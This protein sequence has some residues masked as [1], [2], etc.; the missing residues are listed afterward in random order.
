MLSSFRLLRTSFNLSSATFKKGVQKCH[1]HI[2]ATPNCMPGKRGLL[3]F[4]KE[5]P[6]QLGIISS[7]RFAS[8]DTTIPDPPIPPP[9]EISDIQVLKELGILSDEDALK[10]EPKVSLQSTESLPDAAAQEN[11]PDPSITMEVFPGTSDTDEVLQ[12]TAESFEVP[13]ESSSN[14]Y[15]VKS[16][17]PEI[18]EAL[19]DLPVV[20][21]MASDLQEVL[22]HPTLE[23]VGLGGWGPIGLVQQ[24]LD[25][26]HVTC[27]IPW[28]GSIVVGT[29]VVRI[30]M[31]PLV[32]ISQRNAA[33][34]H[35]I[36]P[37][38][39]VIQVKMSDA[40]E[41]G[42]RIEAAR[43]AQEMMLFM[44]EKG[45][46]PLKNMLVPLAQAPLF[47]SFFLGLRGMA[48]LPVESMKAGGFAWFVDL[49][50]PDQF[51]LLPIITS[52]TLALTIEL[53]TDTARLNSSNMGLMKYFLR[54]MPIIIFPF[55]VGFPSGI[56]VYWAST[57]FISLIQVSILKIPV[58][59]DF[60]K[61][62]KLINHDKTKLPIKDKGFVK[63][64]SDSWTNM[65]ITRELEERQRIDEINFMKAGRGAVKKTFKFDPTQKDASD[66]MSTTL[67]AKKR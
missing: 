19:P 2:Y 62:D 55:T 1:L 56:L 67:Q 47:I 59:R 32:I 57:N 25:F 35:N 65:K 12:S 20:E 24:S 42:D 29:I 54:A 17:S 43:N 8:D 7:K 37:G 61:I 18:S 9:P 51:Y 45:I 16:E 31:F 14:V 3:L 28:W 11:L 36:L 50:V 52:A 4:K 46:N 53:G 10:L 13:P 27:D 21:E 63:S 64:V 58:I 38:L 39:Q 44:K 23:S 40:R 26:L 34:M 15:E 30:L 6:L 22:G 41:R 33:K 5:T 66:R 48:N 49:T 60:F